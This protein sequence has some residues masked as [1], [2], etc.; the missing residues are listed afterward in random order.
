MGNP[1][2]S[3]PLPLCM[4]F[5]RYSQLHRWERSDDAASRDIQ[6]SLL[7]ADAVSAPQH[8]S[9]TFHLGQMD[10]CI[11]IGLRPR[12]GLRFLLVLVGCTTSDTACV[13]V[14]GCTGNFEDLKSRNMQH[15]GSCP[16]CGRVCDGVSCGRWSDQISACTDR[17]RRRQ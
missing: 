3:L 1:C 17:D 7:P 15:V 13:Y 4:S 9:T 5:P 14:P 8:S 16:R 11:P 2:S 12:D 10:G 6:F